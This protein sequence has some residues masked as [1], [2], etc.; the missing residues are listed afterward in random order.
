MSYENRIRLGRTNVRVP[1]VGLGSWSF[2]GL[3]WT[4]NYSVGWSGHDEVEAHRA[5]VESLDRGITHWD[6]ADVYGHGHAEEL[7]GE[8]LKDIPRD[9]VFL[10]TK[11]G[12]DSG[13][14]DFYYQPDFMRRRLERSLRNLRTNH[15][16]LHYLHHCDFGRNDAR[17]DEAVAAVRAFQQEGKV[18]FIGLSD[19]DCSKIA[20]QIDGVDPDVVQ[21]YRNVLDDSYTDSGLATK[22]KDNDLGVVFFS[23]LCHGLL[24]GKYDK[25]TSFP[26]GDHRAN[27]RGF[28]DA[29]VLEALRRAAVRVRAH[30]PSLPEPVLSALIAPLL[31]DYSG[32]CVL[33]GLRSPDQ[34]RAASDAVARLPVCEVEWVLSAYEEARTL[35]G[36]HR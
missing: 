24:L 22:V 18:R 32:S 8:A 31:H 12:Y 21:C 2:G 9:M 28:G 19:W 23:P 15:V 4:G 16:D 3:Q 14:F 13:G 34:V 5:L 1:V 7:I 17:R 30:F 36:D 29:A 10:A 27:V 33:L 20:A 35:V 25:P 6:T 26:D 11:V